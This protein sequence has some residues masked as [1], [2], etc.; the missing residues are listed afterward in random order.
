MVNTKKFSE[1]DAADINDSTT[2][3]VGLSS[4]VNTRE[5]K[6]YTWTTAGRPATPFNGLL[7]LNTDTQTYEFWDSL[8]AMWVQM[9]D[10]NV[11]AILA[12]HAAGQ[13]ASLI[14]LQNQ[15][16]VNNKFVQDLANA[17]FIAQTD[18][19]TLQNAQFLGSL[20]TGIVKN[21]TVTG[22]LSISAPL[23]SIDGLT[24]VANQFLVTTAANTYGTLGALT[25]GQL[26]IGATGLA[27]VLATL[28]AGSGVSIINAA[29]S[30]TISAT[31]TGGTVTSLSA[32]T[33][34]TLTP[35][36][37][38]TTGSIA[39]TIPVV[40]TSGGTGLT[41]YVLGDTL[42]ASAANVLSALPGNIT[43]TKN[44][45]SQTGT[46]AVSAAP[47]WSTISA[48]DIVSGQALTKTDDTNVTLTLG[49][50]PTTALLAAT[51]LTLGWTGQLGVP[52]GG[53]GLA[54]ATIHNL[55][56]GNG[57]SPFTLLPPSATSGIPLISQGA[58]S[59]PA[60]G[61]AVVSG[62]GTGN[63]TFTAY[64]VICAGTTA[65]GAFQ[66]VSG[67]GTLNQVLISQGAGA[68]PIWGSVPGVTPAALTKTDDTNVTLTL[69]GT[70]TTAL[71]QATSLTLGWTGQ[72]GLTRGG[73]N[74]SLTASNGGIVYST[75]TALA[76]LAG[77]ATAGQI[78]RSGATAAPTWSTATYPATAGT[79]G[80]V[81]TSDGTNW[82]SSAPAAS[83]TS[84]IVDDTTT[85]A[86]MY[87][88]WVTA[89]TGSLPLKVSSTKMS[90]NPSTGTMT[91]A[92]ALSS[93][94]GLTSS[95]G[96]NLATFSYVVSAVN[97]LNFSN[98]STGN[99]PFINA[100]GS[101]SS[102]SLTLGTKNGTVAL[103]DVTATTAVALRFI[104]AANTHFIGF[105][106]A[107]AAAGPDVDFQLPTTDGTAG[108]A[109]ITNG[110]HILS[111][112]TPAIPVPTT[113]TFA[114]GSGTYTTPANVKYIRVR[115]WG[116]GGAGGGAASP[117]VA[118][119]AAGAGG[120]GG[121]FFDS[122]ITSPAATYSYGVGAGGTAGTAGN[123]AGNAGGNTTFSTFTANGGAGGGGGATQVGGWNS[124]P[125]AGGSASG[126]QLNVIGAP[127]V[128]GLVLGST[129]S[130]ILGG[131]GGNGAQGGGGAAPPLGGGA[132]GAGSLYGGGGAGG[133]QIASGAAVAGGAGAAG[134]IIVTEYYG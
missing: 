40:P 45:L 11:L 38:T 99:G 119:G 132:A 104:N 37:I 31:G 69:G 102:V 27:P 126:A 78:L 6:F 7:G 121:G 88:T 109:L 112:G 53:S 116:G 107:N 9:A 89:S 1:F 35:D 28:T 114:S 93:S 76:I 55:M 49:G 14:G 83:A 133:A 4:G 2:Q 105:K 101:D 92:G 131:A 75:A 50:S 25:D 117:S 17:T 64:S 95:T 85:N 130:A 103:V 118:Q 129:A 30:I 15:S 120:G 71:L 43:L 91:L 70:P 97:Y 32:G 42:Y 56:I 61:T 106:A 60:F 127:G 87:P 8:A 59:D 19:G 16:N 108:Q 57:T 22:V 66:N 96:L 46:G 123:N 122:I 128:N 82:L 113:Q 86:T 79:S 77:T 3:D 23:T 98:N 41:S 34:I 68:L 72:L 33:G 94:T 63:T 12:S 67:V 84:V 62:G 111:F 18:N 134:F 115:G 44:F 21:T 124:T 48:S 10:T 81:L 5:K 58:A 47:A 100:T 52:R 20:T 110:S 80:N 54:A 39:L 29:G 90:F 74:A 36:P 65:T 26:I 73:S 125:G 24:T 13:G 51:S